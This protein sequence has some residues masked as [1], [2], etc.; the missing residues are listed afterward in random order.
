MVR[1]TAPDISEHQK[2]L[3]SPSE[4]RY[5]ANRGIFP[6]LPAYYLVASVRTAGLLTAYFRTSA[7][8]PV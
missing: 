3:P 2:A 8:M 5:G 4:A 6:G 1:K 7:I